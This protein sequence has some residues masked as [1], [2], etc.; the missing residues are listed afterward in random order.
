MRRSLHHGAQ[1]ESARANSDYGT[2]EFAAVRTRA[3][4]TSEQLQPIEI[5]SNSPVET[6]VSQRRREE[7]LSS[8]VQ[9]PHGRRA[10][11]SPFSR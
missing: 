3:V 1:L 2:L 11:R 10:P 8:V 7:V 6:E 4:P 5:A 9:D